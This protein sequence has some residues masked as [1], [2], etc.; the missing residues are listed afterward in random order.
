MKILL[1]LSVAIASFIIGY[2]LGEGRKK[3][4]ENKGM[5]GSIKKTKS[6]YENL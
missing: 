6:F 4:R 2:I 5:N 3:A 1:L